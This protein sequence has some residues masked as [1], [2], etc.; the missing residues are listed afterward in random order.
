MQILPSFTFTYFRR[1]THLFPVF[2]LSP[3][4]PPTLTY[5]YPDREVSSRLG[6]LFDVQGLESDVGRGQN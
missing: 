3:T 4:W 6:L 1:R 5:A 2:F